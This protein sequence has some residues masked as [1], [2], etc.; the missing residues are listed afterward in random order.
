LL[1]F[2][3]VS[4]VVFF[5]GVNLEE[6]V[7]AAL[8]GVQVILLGGDGGE[9]KTGQFGVVGYHK[10]VLDLAIFV[11][12]RDETVFASLGEVVTSNVQESISFH[13]EGGGP[14]TSRELME[15]AGVEHSRSVDDNTEDAVLERFS[16]VKDGLLIVHGETGGVG[17]ATI[18]DRLEHGNTKINHEETSGGVFERALS[19][20]TRVGEEKGVVLFGEEHGV[21]SLKSAS[22]K[23]LD[24]RDDFNSV[25][26]HSLG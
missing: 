12:N 6:R 2:I 5:R 25:I 24:N 20:R 17:E 18:D 23:I 7:S 22:I 11:K 8:S 1:S 16:N 3:F 19:K 14:K 15:D 21:G 13:G 4:S 9:P 26:S 10:L